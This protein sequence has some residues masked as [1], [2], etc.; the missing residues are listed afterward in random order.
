MNCSKIDSFT[1]NVFRQNVSAAI[2]SAYHEVGGHGEEEGAS[3]GEKKLGDG[4]A[5]DG[6]VPK[7]LDQSHLDI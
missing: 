3:C 6:K 1:P 2:G 7:N 4:A 5:V